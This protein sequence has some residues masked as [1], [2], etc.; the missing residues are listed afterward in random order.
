MSSRK[1][2][3]NDLELYQLKQFFLDVFFKE[4]WLIILLMLTSF[5][6]GAYFVWKKPENF[7][8]QGQI[9]IKNEFVGN[10]QLFPWIKGA[11][12]YDGAS[13]NDFMRNRGLYAKYVE[14]SK[15]ED[16]AFPY[17]K[18]SLIRGFR[19]FANA[20]E[21]FS[22]PGQAREEKAESDEQTMN[23]TF[24]T[25]H[26]EFAIPAVKGFLELYFQ[27]QNDYIKEEINRKISEYRSESESIQKRHDEIVNEMKLLRAKT[28]SLNIKEDMDAIVFLINTNLG[29]VDSLKG[30]LDLE[31]ETLD[32]LNQQLNE[33]LKEDV[34]LS[35]YDQ[36]YADLKLRLVE[37]EGERDLAIAAYDEKHP[38]ILSIDI[39]LKRIRRELKEAEDKFKVRSARIA[40]DPLAN[41]LHKQIQT[42]QRK[43][44]EVLEE[45]VN[46]ER[47]LKEQKQRYSNLANYKSKIDSMKELEE[48]LASDIVNFNK[49]VE[50]LGLNK[51]RDLITF[52]YEHEL[53]D[54]VPFNNTFKDYGYALSLLL[55]LL[56]TGGTLYTKYFFSGKF[57]RASEV[58]KLLPFQVVGLVTL[59]K[60]ATDDNA[61]ADPKSY[62]SE[63][64][65]K[66]RANLGFLQG[67]ARVFSITSSQKS[68]GKSFIAYNTA[69]SL[70]NMNKK[71]ILI[72]GDFRLPRLHK[73]LNLE[74]LLGFV[75]LLDDCAFE[76]VLQETP[77]EN[78]HFI[79]S[80]IPSS[81]STDFLHG[82]R[83]EEVLAKLRNDYDYVV[84]DTPPLAFSTD[85]Y[86][87]IKKCDFT[88]FVLAIDR[89]K[90]VNA[91][92]YL[93]ELTKLGIEDIGLVVNRVAEV[94]LFGQYSYRYYY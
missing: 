82:Q 28:N 43:L 60:R 87:L 26:K 65:R 3:N 32:N 84:F 86:L 19:L 81:A 68:D 78:L 58:P 55:A 46:K 79:A 80:G 51:D 11:S 33:R 36:S 72:D 93:N 85:P 57:M 90:V 37:L 56:S 34:S 45:K 89:T 5:S 27:K 14:E 76:D 53:S 77:M 9:R 88:L 42:T 29:I 41:A 61:F 16:K 64:F 7:R 70:A 50:I 92:K 40:T 71:V 54:P 69:L 73:I 47:L 44:R 31:Q 15:K 17:S 63:C 94:E 30:K 62:V 13:F 35:L 6:I 21:A 75:D 22:L 8:A 23:F 12:E 67:D 20:E 52:D 91:E 49:Y 10:R 83:F 74:N 24:D 1:V 4:I 2:Q 59:D 48:V 18:W 66:L 38:K 25:P 39:R